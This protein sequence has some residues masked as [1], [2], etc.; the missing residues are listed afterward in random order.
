MYQTI[1]SVLFLRYWLDLTE[2][3]VMWHLSDTG[4]AK[5]AK[6]APW[7]Q[8]ACIFGHHM[9]QFDVKK[10]LNVLKKYPVSVLCLQPTVYRLIMQEDL[11][12]VRFKG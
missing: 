2:H 7:W 6:F 10:T 11:N 9:P 12:N 4:V 1:I 5:S 8:G 3:D